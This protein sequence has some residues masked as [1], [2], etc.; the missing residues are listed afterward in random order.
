MSEPRTPAVLYAAKSTI[1]KRKSIP[2]QLEDCRKKAEEEGWEVVGEF[3]DEGFSAYSGNRGPDLERAKRAAQEAAEERGVRCMLVVQH[4]D[5]LARGAGDAPGA[6][7]SLTEIYHAMARV[8]VRLR[9]VQNDS[10]TENEVYIALASRQAWE[11]SERKSKAIKDGKRRRAERGEANGPMKFGYDFEDPD[12]EKKVRVP[13]SDAP[14]VVAMF[15]RYDGGENYSAI[16]RWLNAQGFTTKTDRAFDFRAVR[17]ILTNPYYAGKI[18][19]ASGELI[20]GQHEPLVS[21][22]LWERVNEKITASLPASAGKGGRP[23]IEPSLLTGVMNCG[24]C[25]AGMHHRRDRVNPIYVCKNVRSKT[26]VCSAEP[27]DAAL[28]ERAM[29]GHLGSVFVDLEELVE[30]LTEQHAKERG[31]FERELAGYMAEREELEKKVGAL[32]ADYTEKVAEGKGTPAEIASRQI[33]KLGGELTK[34]NRRVDEAGAKLDEWETSEADPAN[35]VLDWWNELKAAIDGEV[36]NAKS[37]REANAALRERFAAV[38]V[39]RTPWGEAEL[40]FILRDRPPGAPPISHWF[41]AG[42]DEQEV[43]KVDVRRLLARLKQESETGADGAV[44]VAESGED[45]LGKTERETLVWLK[46]VISPISA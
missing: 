13:D 38:F 21:V 26:G 5:R 43:E 18:R 20:D 33:D 44:I 6:A 22:A 34:L 29:L 23:P 19:L 41:T 42:E 31:V 15:E 24:E 8:N 46:P 4:T 16:A 14:A 25:G 36:V 11:E 17:D 10:A 9:S 7:Q 12:A 45:Q 3:K 40:A 2:T 32:E 1:D 27:I 37:V 35:A 28:T 39:G 30:R